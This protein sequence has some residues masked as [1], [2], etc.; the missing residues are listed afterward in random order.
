MAIPE[1]NAGCNNFIDLFYFS[2]F[3]ITFSHQ[4]IIFEN[5]CNSGY[6][7]ITNSTQLSILKKSHT[8]AA[9]R[10]RSRNSPVVSSQSLQIPPHANAYSAP[11]ATS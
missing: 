5:P 8:L 3:Q 7:Q 11:S 10:Q 6:S 1:R 9:Q 2:E 4:D